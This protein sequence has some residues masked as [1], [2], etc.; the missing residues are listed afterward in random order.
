MTE[1]VTVAV[2]LTKQPPPLEQCG[3]KGLAQGSNSLTDLIVATP[4]LEPD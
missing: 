1:V 4:V 2:V 3:V